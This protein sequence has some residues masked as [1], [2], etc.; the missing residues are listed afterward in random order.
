[1]AL[2]KEI[3]I[4]AFDDCAFSFNQKKVRIVGPIFRGGERMDA[5]LSTNI[6]KDGLDSTG[7]L[8]DC[9]NQ[10]SHK[11]QLQY[12]LLDGISYAGLNMVDVQKLNE[13]TGLP[14]IVIQRKKPNIKKFLLACKH[15]D[16]FEKR[17]EIVKKAGK[18]F[19]TNNVYYQ[20]CGLGEEKV[21]E[22]ISMTT[23]RGN[24]PEPLRVAHI[25]ASGLS[26]SSKGGV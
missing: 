9:I 8:F 5:M 4:I 12:V 16:N 26:G 2:K 18:V 11:D 22:I 3:R 24:M 15:L 17:K 20:K 19:K 10:T 7:K 13:K 25:I 23:K 1:M 21:N 6:K 14:V